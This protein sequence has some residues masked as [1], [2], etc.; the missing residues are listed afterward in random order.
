M[1][2]DEPNEHSALLLYDCATAVDMDFG[3][4]ASSATTSKSAP[5]MSRHFGI[6]DNVIYVIRDTYTQED[7]EDRLI[8]NLENG[9]PIIYR[10]RH[11]DGGHAFNLDGLSASKNQN[12]FH[13]NWGWNG[14]GNG[15]YTLDDLKPGNNSYTQAQA[16]IFRIQPAIAVSSESITQDI[17]SFYPNPASSLIKINNMASGRVSG[18]KIYSLSGV[19]MRSYNSSSTD[20][21][22]DISDLKKGIYIFE[23]TFDDASVH[24]RKIVKQ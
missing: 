7:W 6:A 23:A 13:V 16:A 5:A 10:G 12:F 17:I 2:P 21:A 3:P 15:Y 20:G 8:L 22:I 14:S 18:L 1:L 4:T 19:L 9:L 11:D 24:R